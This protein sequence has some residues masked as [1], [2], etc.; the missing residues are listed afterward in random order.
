MKKTTLLLFIIGLSQIAHNQIVNVTFQVDLTYQ[1]INS[2]GIHIAGN[3]QDTAGF[4]ANW[5]PD[6]T[7]LVDSSNNGIYEV[8]VAVPS[9]AYLYKFINGNTWSNVEVVP[10]SCGVGVDLNR[11]IVIGT[12][13]TT[14]APVCFSSCLACL[15]T[16]NITFKVGMKGQVIDSSGVHITGDFQSLLGL[17]DWDPSS[18]ALSDT[19]GDSIYE[20]MVAIQPGT[21]EFKYV[22]GNAWGKD[23]A[24]P[25]A[26]TAAGSN[27]RVVAFSADTVLPPICFGTCLNCSGVK[28]SAT[29]KVD[30]SA[31]VSA[32]NRVFVSGY[33]NGWSGSA[34][35]LQDANGDSIWEITLVLPEGVHE[36]K[37]SIDNWTDQELF[38]GNEPCVTG[39]GSFINRVFNLTADTTFGA[40][41]FG[42]CSLCPAAPAAFYDIILKVDMNNYPTSFN[43]VYVSGDFNSWCGTCHRMSD[44]NLDGIYEDTLRLPTNN[45]E[46]KFTVDNWSDQEIFNGSEVCTDTNGPN[47]NRVFSLDTTDTILGPYCFNTCSTCPTRPNVSTTFLVDMALQTIDS[48]G[49]FVSGSFNLF[50]KDTLTHIGDSI[51]S[52]TATVDSGKTFYYRYVNGDSLELL[53]ANCSQNKIGAVFRIHTSHVVDT[54]PKVCYSQC[55]TCASTNFYVTFQ[56][57]L[58][59]LIPNSNGV[60]VSG[61]F[62]EAAGYPNNWSASDIQM[63]LQSNGTYQV[64]LIL[65]SDTFE[66]KFLN[67]NTWNDTEIVPPNCGVGSPANRRF[68]LSS[69]TVL[70]DFCFGTCG[71]CIIQKKPV[72]FKVNMKD[73]TVNSS[74]I[75][76]T[77]DFIGWEADSLQMTN[78]INQVYEV[79]VMIDSG[80][81]IEYKFLNGNSFLGE[82]TVP[83]SCGIPN[84]IGGY[85]RFYQVG[86][87]NVLDSICFSSCSLCIVTPPQVNV[88]FNID[89]NDETI[90]PDGIHIT[91]EFNAWGLTP[92]NNQGNNL[93]STQLSLDSNGTIEYKFV[94][95]FSGFENVPATCGVPDGFGGLNRSLFAF[96]SANLNP[97]CFSLCTPC[98]TA[99]TASDVSFKVDMTNELV[100]IFGVHVAG[101]F[102]N[103]NTSTHS[104]TDSNND[105]IFEATFNLTIGDTLEY[106]YYNGLSSTNI[107][108]TDSLTNCGVDNG[109]GVYERTFVVKASN[110]FIAPVCFSRCHDCLPQ[111]PNGLVELSSND[112]NYWVASNQ[113]NML[114]DKPIIGSVLIYD[115]LGKELLNKTVNSA[116]KVI[117]LNGISKGVY[118]LKIKTDTD[119]YQVKFIK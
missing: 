104:L 81:T 51:Y 18:L 109:S 61:D 68:I 89:L 99:V 82:E 71:S 106:N 57:S 29:F 31:Y 64:T 23:E 53:P 39:T 5:V 60:F 76:L 12:N 50:N 32:F 2:N 112:L 96:G 3:F 30:M 41:C 91:G 75:F 93:Y 63:A 42:A 54:I 79:T 62:M 69:D 117:N 13:D 115:L 114:F 119:S 28:H 73:D 67:G 27:N 97:V 49:V 19:N 24:V 92:L 110:N 48:T 111:E 58:G 90:S 94:N 9:G 17:I 44:I 65:P 88:T 113:L 15:P 95:G 1:T 38:T 86:I 100:S 101:N 107:E 70:L 35:T 72:T 14:I 4:G 45:Y 26:C 47:F 16:S 105:S 22:N 85:N 59:G 43:Q 40:Y 74:G 80:Q 20:L 7:L 56:L 103:Y 66:Y 11:S 21:Y 87:S 6:T 78:S 98:T 84:G 37:F 10:A 108:I 118:I 8:T 46:Y 102:N 83:Q 34:D 77:G 55:D 25:Q 52:F 36:Y 33:F 116:N